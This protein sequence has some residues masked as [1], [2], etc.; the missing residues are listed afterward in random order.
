MLTC[1]VIRVWQHVVCMALDKN[2]L[3]DEYLCERCQPRPFDKKRAKAVQRTRE[4]EIFKTQV[5]LDTSDDEKKTLTPGML[6][7]RK[8][9][10]RKG[11]GVK[12]P[13]LPEKKVDKKKKT[14]K[15]R[16]LKSELTGTAGKEAGQK[17]PSP[18]KN[19]RRKSASATDIETEEENPNDAMALR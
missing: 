16:S 2:N 14:G 1:N 9:G 18:R 10:V 17:K 12:K 3:P 5:H 7:G 11:L 19:P 4:K 15:R 13:G 8:P 6:K